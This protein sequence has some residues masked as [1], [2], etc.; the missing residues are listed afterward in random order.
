M[1]TG[2]LKEI[3]PPKIADTY[4]GDFNEIK[5]N[6]NDCIDTMTGLLLKRIN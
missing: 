4:N 3:F 5:N 6:L 1:L 2:S